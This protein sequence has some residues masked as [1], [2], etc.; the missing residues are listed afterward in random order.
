ME[1]AETET[2]EL[3]TLRQCVSVGAGKTVSQSCI[4]WREKLEITV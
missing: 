3:D 4:L 1:Q 2:D